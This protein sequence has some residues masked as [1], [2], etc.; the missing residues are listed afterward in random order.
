MKLV[1]GSR[2]LA[3]FFPCAATCDCGAYCITLHLQLKLSAQKSCFYAE[4]TFRMLPDAPATLREREELSPLAA[5]PIMKRN[6]KRRR[7]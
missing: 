1:T 6:K 3:K 2:K 5:F 4:Y 7:K